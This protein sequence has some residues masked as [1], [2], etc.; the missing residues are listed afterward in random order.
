[1]E[2]M[3]DVISE[4]QSMVKEKSLFFQLTWTLYRT[5]VIIADQK[6]E[7]DDFDSAINDIKKMLRK[8]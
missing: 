3:C 5:N 8:M 4:I 6:F 2:C 7:Y 1:M